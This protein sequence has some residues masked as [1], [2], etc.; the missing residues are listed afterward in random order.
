MATKFIYDP[1]LKRKQETISEILSIASKK[2]YPTQDATHLASFIQACF[3]IEEDKA[4]SI[5]TAKLAAEKELMWKRAEER[6]RAEEEE[7]LASIDMELPLPVAPMPSS[8][9]LEGPGGELPILD[10]SEGSELSELDAMVPSPDG[11]LSSFNISSTP[12]PTGGKQEYVLQIY[13]SP[14]GVLIDKNDFG[15]FTYYVV[16]PHINKQSLKSALSLYRKDLEKDN[17]L[18]DDKNFVAKMSQKVSKK[19]GLPST[20]LF[21]R[22]LR[23]YMER[24]ILGAG[25]FDPILFDEKVRT[26]NCSGVH[27]PISVEVKPYGNIQS[28]VV[29]EDN[30]YINQLMQRVAQATMA[31]LDDSNPILD[32]TFQGFKFEGVKGIGGHTSKLTIRRLDN[33]I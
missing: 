18:F 17:S 8:L 12:I 9:E 16:E 27:K 29:I 3:K 31:K 14:V 10:L 33:D 2:P 15:K 19:F 20:D 32:A 24:D 26:I 28:N 7:A 25:P 21:T 1:E 23:Y 6:K 4:R 13:D 5:L 22:K 11:S 30:D